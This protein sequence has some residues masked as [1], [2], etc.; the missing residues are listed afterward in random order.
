MTNY[1]SLKTVAATAQNLVYSMART[2]E[3]HPMPEY[4]FP[5]T[6]IHLGP[7][8]SWEQKMVFEWAFLWLS[9]KIMGHSELSE[10]A[11]NRLNELIYKE[12]I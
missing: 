9:F 10:I 8:P 7:N 4:T 5:G 1:M 11:K 6:G 3:N 2:Q 12:G